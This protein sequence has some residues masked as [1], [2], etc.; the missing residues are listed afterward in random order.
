MINEQYD[1]VECPTS[2]PDPTDR[3]N[4]LLFKKKMGCAKWKNEPEYIICLHR[5]QLNSQSKSET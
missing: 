4:T 1:S 2:V 5:Y 3:R